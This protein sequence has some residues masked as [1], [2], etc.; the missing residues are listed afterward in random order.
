MELNRGWPIWLMLCAGIFCTTISPDHSASADEPKQTTSIDTSALNSLEKRFFM[1]TFG[2]EGMSHR[3]AR[4][5]ERVFGKTMS[6][7]DG[8]RLAQLQEAAGPDAIFSAPSAAT[9]APTS[10][11]SAPSVPAA[12][13]G[14]ALSSP[15]V[16]KSKAPNLPV[17]N[18]VDRENER[19]RVQEAAGQQINSLLSEGVTAWR[20]HNVDLA[21]DRFKQVVR[22]D[23]ANGQAYFSLGIIYE[24]QGDFSNAVDNYQKASKTQ[25]ENKDYASAIVQAQK[26]LAAK[27]QIDDKHAELSKLSQEALATYNRG[28]YLSALDLYKQIDEKFPDQA[29]NKYNIGSVY[30]IMRQPE[31]A[32]PYYKKAREIDPNDPKIS[33]AYDTLQQ[34]LKEQEKA[35]SASAA[36]S[37]NYN[38]AASVAYP[39]PAGPSKHGR[40]KPSNSEKNSKQSHQTYGAEGYIKNYGLEV[41][42]SSK[43]LRV[44]STI[45]GTRAAAAGVQSGDVIKAINGAVVDTTEDADRILAGCNPIK[46]LQLTIQRDKRMLQMM[47]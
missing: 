31:L 45:L 11:S 16:S 10:A 14:T 43:G 8:E 34:A 25:P 21:L 24:T 44:K 15:A 42:S 41:K 5:E 9:S 38:P 1:Q 33:Q 32:L 28:E 39:T 6:G 3:L 37:A 40:Q 47:I 2:D 35:R 12:P 23:P 29:I 20:Q 22:L 13:S 7:A 18:S 36:A 27:Q 19:L 17:T 4:L 30:L 26:K 46:Q